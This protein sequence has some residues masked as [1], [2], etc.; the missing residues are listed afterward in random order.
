MNQFDLT[1]TRRGKNPVCRVARLVSPGGH[2]RAAQKARKGDVRGSIRD[3]LTS[4]LATLLLL[5]LR[6]IG[7]LITIAA[8]GIDALCSI[9][10][11][12]GRRV[13]KDELGYE[14]TREYIRRSNSQD[15]RFNGSPAAT[16]TRVSRP[17]RLCEAIRCTTLSY[18]H[19]T[20]ASRPASSSTPAG[21]QGTA[22]ASR[23]VP[24]AS[25]YPRER[26]IDNSYAVRHCRYSAIQARF[27]RRCDLWTVGAS[28]RAGTPR[29]G[30][31]VFTTPGSHI[32]SDDPK[33]QVTRRRAFTHS[34]PAGMSIPP[35]PWRH[36]L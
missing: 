21:H 33:R 27:E 25:D 7:D 30:D 26:I 14:V 35:F 2:L 9:P 19:A 22:A 31:L 34:R 4:F 23:G 36:H 1:G 20:S 15:P 10:K 29:G 12:R 6:N 24:R 17:H 16:T 11:P 13:D 28:D 5:P 18:E 32:V 8:G 3:T